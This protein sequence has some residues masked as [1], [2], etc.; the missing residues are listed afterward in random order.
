[1]LP[2]DPRIGVR[3]PHESRQH[4]SGLE[5][6]A[7]AASAASVCVPTLSRTCHPALRRAVRADTSSRR[8]RALAECV[9][10]AHALH[11][12]N[13]AAAFRHYAAG[14]ALAPRDAD[15]AALHGVALRS[16]G[17]LHDAQRE[18]IRS[19]ALD[20][21][22][23]DSYT[24]LA[25]SY[26]MAGDRPQAAQAFLAAAS[27]RPNDAMAWRDAAESLRL[28][29]R[30]DDGLA[31]ARH[32]AALAPHDPSIANTTA[33]LLHRAGHIAAALA[34]CAE[35]R[36]HAPDDLHLALTHAMLCRTTGDY[37]PGWSLYERRLELPEFVQRRFPPGTPRWDG[38]ALNGQRILVR[39]EQGLGDQLQFLRWACLLRARGASHVT[40]QVAPS[41]VTLVRS[42]PDIDSVIASDRPAPP[43]QLHVDAAS[44][45]HL[46]GTGAD[47]LAHRIPYLCP[48]DLSATAFAPLPRTDSRFRIGIVWSGSPLQEDNRFR[49]VPLATLLP[50]VAHPRV[51]LVVLQQGP[52]RSQL[53]ALAATQRN[54]LL[55]VA[56]ACADMNDTAI[57]AS[58]CDLVLSVC[59]SVVH[60]AGALGLPTWLL[61]AHP[62][63]W[64][65]GAAGATSSLYPTM[66]L[67]RQQRAGDWLHVLDE[68]RAALSHAVEAH[69]A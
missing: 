11:A 69:G 52:G 42:A 10:G 15:I 60:L 17:R 50:A 59:T 61:L 43:H 21:S 14:V 3:L 41:L 24:Q 54:T 47:M 29:D 7:G 37:D 62:A 31:A 65:W 34:L 5:E 1:V 67:F 38:R 51:Q 45:P 44:L 20:A 25:Q 9:A 53:D 39:A 56:P 36:R 8:D 12:G 66:R 4:P 48:T 32:A 33:L 64:R 49:S 35:A 27:L 19:I 40:V 55:D 22:R 63:E 30:L 13:S 57:V 23:A 2:P 28:A 18:L 46:L 58:Q 26:R 6:M 16:A 68:V